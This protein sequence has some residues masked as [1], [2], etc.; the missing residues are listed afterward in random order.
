MNLREKTKDKIVG[1]LIDCLVIHKLKAGDNAC[2]Y[3]EIGLEF[4]IT[5]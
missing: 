2:Q 4:F 5:L 3:G 1:E